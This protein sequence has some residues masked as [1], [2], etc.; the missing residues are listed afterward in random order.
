MRNSYCRVDMLSEP[1]IMNKFKRLWKY[2]VLQSLLAGA[3][4]LVL[5]AALG[6]DKMVTV[7]S[8]GASAFI[9]FAMPK[10]VSAQTRNV[11]GGHLVGLACGALC[12]LIE[13]PCFVEYPLAVT[14]AMFLMV[15][16]DVEHP[17][18]AG[19]ALAMTINEGLWDVIVA[20]MLSA[21]LLSQCR[22]YMRN[23][24]KDLV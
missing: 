3:V 15:A 18:A 7:A 19:T 23:Y 9:V 6:R 13:Q 11:I 20:V 17:P 4:V 8:I 16:L 14:M 1:T 10:S 12:Y 2:Y 22:Y 24:L 21:V 5:V